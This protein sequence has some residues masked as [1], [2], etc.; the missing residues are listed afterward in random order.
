MN[1]DSSVELEVGDVINLP[2]LGQLET[3]KKEYN[4]KAKLRELKRGYTEYTIKKNDTWSNMAIS[5]Y[6]DLPC[7]QWSSGKEILMR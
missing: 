6:P 3:V 5:F 2:S 1:P 7:I 4:E